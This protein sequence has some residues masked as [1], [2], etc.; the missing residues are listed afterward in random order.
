MPHIYRLARD[1]GMEPQSF[2]AIDNVC[3]NAPP[4]AGDATQRPLF[5]PVAQA[6]EGPS[7]VAQMSSA[8]PSGIQKM[9]IDATEYIEDPVPSAK[10]IFGKQKQMSQIREYDAKGYR[11]PSTG[12]FVAPASA[13]EPEVQA[14]EN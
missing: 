4:A 8:M 3:F 13:L 14:I 12:G 10:A 1:A 5:T 6:A 2:C 9:L 7:I 11:V